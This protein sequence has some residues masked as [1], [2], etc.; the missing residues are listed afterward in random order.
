MRQRHNTTKVCPTVVGETVVNVPE[1]QKNH[2]S[3]L[4]ACT[5]GTKIDACPGFVY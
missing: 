2:H 4:N 5:N 1:N 3:R